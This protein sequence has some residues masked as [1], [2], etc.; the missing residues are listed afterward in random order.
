MG[1]TFVKGDLFQTEGLRAYAHGANCAGAIYSG[2]S[3]AFKRRWPAMFEEYRLRCADGRFHLGDVF[4]WTAGDETIYT[5]GIQEHWKQKAKLPALSKALRRVVE[6]AEAARIE[7]VGL[8]RIGGGPLGFDWMRV[9]NIVT[10]VGLSTDVE[11]VVFEQF[12]RGP[13]RSQ[14]VPG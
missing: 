13:M 8:P 2:V 9:R 3:V 14:H 4:V 11:L 7:R 12:I 1:S 5:L 6:L 10:E